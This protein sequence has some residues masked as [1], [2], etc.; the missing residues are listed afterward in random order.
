[1]P[2]NFYPG[3]SDGSTAESDSCGGR[4]AYNNM[5]LFMCEKGLFQV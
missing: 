4:E 1:M 2:L 3:I 5:L